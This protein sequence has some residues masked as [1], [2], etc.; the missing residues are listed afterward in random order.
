ML[1][2]TL[3][4]LARLLC[5]ASFSIL[6]KGNGNPFPWYLVKPN[7]CLVNATAAA[8]NWKLLFK[9]MPTKG[10]VSF[11]IA[12]MFVQLLSISLHFFLI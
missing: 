3:D 4:A 9:N 5:G 12:L 7:G 1:S 8:L 11:G 6:L 10:L 2:W